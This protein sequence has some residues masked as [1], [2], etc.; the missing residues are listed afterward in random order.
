MALQYLGW[1][2]TAAT[3]FP[4]AARLCDFPGNRDLIASNQ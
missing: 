2:L 1:L 4:A 3:A